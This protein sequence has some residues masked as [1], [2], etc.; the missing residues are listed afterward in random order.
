M[1]VLHICTTDSG[2]AGLC[3]LRIHESLLKQG[4]DSKVLVLEKRSPNA[5]VFEYGR[6][7]NTL[8]KAF[9]KVLRLLHLEITNYN[10]VFNLSVRQKRCYT[11]PTSIIDVSRYPL[12]QEADVIHLHW[13]NHFVDYPS[14]FKKVKKPFVWTLHDENLFLGIAHYTESKSYGGDLE[15][16]YYH[17][18]MKIVKGIERLGIVFLSEM[19]YNQ[20]RQHEMI[21]NAKTTI[22]NNAV[23][24]NNYYP[25]KKNIAR[26]QMG[27]PQDAVVFVFVSAELFDSRKGLDILVKAL[28]N[29]Q[30]L[31]VMILAIGTVG[32]Y[33]VSSTVNAI[34][35]IYNIEK[36]SLAY[37]CADYFVMPSCQEAFAQT[38]IEAMS[39]GVP[40]IVFP[41]GGTREL[42]NKTN[43]ILCNGF[44]QKD[45]EEGINKA[46]NTVYD[47]DEIRKDVIA[48]FSP[49][50]IA[51]SYMDFYNQ[52]L[53]DKKL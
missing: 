7:K 4:V 13:I 32:S 52:I 53:L 22:I 31:N 14:F 45:L 8:W 51:K 19:M 2:G 27:I 24:Y 42:I 48:R 12:I 46:M 43:G 20:Y 23:D 9:N 18:K 17:K 16:E 38:P 25:A 1:K 26:Q 28:E 15:A 29:M 10:K 3:C 6:W 39:C 21:L 33:Q 49:E 37:S 44:T 11:L 30:I 35:P 50:K 36:M 41:V 5:R 40:A 47:S 34:G